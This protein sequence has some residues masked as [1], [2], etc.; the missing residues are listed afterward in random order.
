MTAS[1]QGKPNGTQ[2]ALLVNGADAFLF[3]STGIDSPV[4]IGA[5][6]AANAMTLTLTKC[7]L[8]FRSATL[9][10]GTPSYV[11]TASDLSLTIPSG[12]TLGTTN[13]VASRLVL[14]A[15][16]NAGT[17]ELGVVNLAGGVNLDETGL[18]STTAI[19]A[20][21]SSASV[22]YSNTARTNV[23][24]RVIGS[25]DSTQATAG[26]WA[27]A[28][29]LVQP[30]MG[31][32]MDALQSLGFGQS[33]QT[34]TVG[35]TRVLGTTYWNTTGKPI[36]VTLAWGASASGSSTVTIGGVLLATLQTNSVISTHSYF[37][38]FMVP[39]GQSYVVGSGANI[40]SWTETR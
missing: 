32:A 5:S 11:T 27:S 36:E 12:A 6:V 39:V 21:A 29:S 33:V 9:T 10:S 37:A 3:D 25:I 8:R 1:L 2:G 20:A 13:A 18:I 26:T 35:G 16:N 38:Q 24:Y 28:P 14:L 40:L 19:S 4:S 7:G 15:L 22:V 34:F 23:A 31:N 17:M 30:Y